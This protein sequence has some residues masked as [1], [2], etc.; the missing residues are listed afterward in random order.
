M[1]LTELNDR[2]DVLAKFTAG[3]LLPVIIRWQGRRYW[4][5]KLNLHHSERKGG[6]TLH[7]YAVSTEVGDCTLRYSQQDLSWRLLEVSFSG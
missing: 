2:V 5:Q 4:V 7:F 6:D 1:V 3:K